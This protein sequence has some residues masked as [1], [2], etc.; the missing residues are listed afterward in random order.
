MSL[1]VVGS[2]AFDTIKT[3]RG[4]VSDALGG[5]AVYFS[6]AA[7]QFAPVRLVGVVGG[8]FD[9]AHVDMLRSRSIDT[10]G[11]EVVGSGKTFRWTGEY[12]RDM[13]HR[14]TLEVDLNV[15]EDFQPKIP[16]SFRDSKFVFLANGPP[17]T[18]LSVLDQVS[19]T[20]T[21]TVAD[22][23]DLW[24]TTARPD[25]LELISRI[26]G[27]VVNDSEAFLLTEAD[28]MIQA[29]RQILE[30]GP[31]L[32]VIKKGEHGAVL[33]TRG[34]CVPLPAYPTAAVLDPTGAGDSFAGAMMG[35]LAKLD[36]HDDAALKEAI[37]HGTIASSFTVEDYGTKR[38]AA[39]SAEET[40]TRFDDYRGFLRI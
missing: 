10:A 11:L 18:Q 37:V 9:M 34:Q 29:G 17:V 35:Y 23:M 1:L 36:R 8:D 6:I 24:I 13:N 39:I 3:P 4:E 12:S 14:E 2:I 21:F 25:L 7:S 30:L 22:T 38:L 26:D 20:P 19:D 40:R 5:S 33:F 31:K 32:V 15:F 28:N 16:D 27:L